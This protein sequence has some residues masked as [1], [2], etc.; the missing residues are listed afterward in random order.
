MVNPKRNDTS[1]KNADEPEAIAG[2][3]ADEIL[4]A[5]VDPPR[6]ETTD[7]PRSPAKVRPLSIASFLMLLGVAIILLG[8][9]FWLTNARTYAVIIVGVG[10][11]ALVIGI[12]SWILR[13]Y[14]NREK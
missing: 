1:S 5:P 11:L 12:L 2:Y 13:L 7:P 14:N 9:M 6:P 8:G 3:P 10:A 4:K